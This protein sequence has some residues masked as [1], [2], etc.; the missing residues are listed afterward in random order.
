MK[1]IQPVALL[2]LLLLLLNCPAIAGQT[3]F[4]CSE[5]YGQWNVPG[6]AAS[7]ARVADIRFRPLSDPREIRRIRKLPSKSLAGF[8]GRY[9]VRQITFFAEPREQGNSFYEPGKVRF[10]AEAVRWAGT[11]V[12]YALSFPGTPPGDAADV[13]SGLTEDDPDSKAPREIPGWGVFPATPDQNIPLVVLQTYAGY[14]GANSGTNA[15]T[16]RLIDFRDGQPRSVAQLDCDE[17]IRGGACT[18]YDELFEPQGKLQ[19]DWIA[20]RADFQC[21]ESRTSNWSWGSVTQIRKA[22]GCYSP[23]WARPWFWT[24][25]PSQ[26]L[27]MEPSS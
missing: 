13:T 18:A 4:G 27:S 15:T 25:L 2:L 5:S 1:S 17:R 12:D 26:A 11:R 9:G 10:Y 6:E 14:M 7:L 23:T 21:L 22:G 20:A 19:C 24:V 3:K 16:R 8:A